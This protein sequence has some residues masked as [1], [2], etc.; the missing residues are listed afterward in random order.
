MTRDPL[1][2]LM[3]VAPPVILAALVAGFFLF[4]RGT[5]ESAFGARIEQELRLVYPDATRFSAK[6][7]DPPRIEAFVG[8]A[9]SGTER[10]IGLAYYTDELEPQ[11]RGYDGPIRTLV[12]LGLDGRIVGVAVLDH[13]EPYGYFSIDLPAFRR[14]FVGKDISDRFRVGADVDAVSRATITVSSVA[15][16]ISSGGRRI[17]RAYLEDTDRVP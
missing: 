9:A 15:R 6:T 1:D 17:V 2:L 4:T 14:Q 10:R 13:R 3:L 8:D 5:L 11:E 16:G 12:G 7:G